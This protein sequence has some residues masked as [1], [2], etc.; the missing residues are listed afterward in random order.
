MTWFLDK[1][2][3]VIWGNGEELLKEETR[4]EDSVEASGQD[5]RG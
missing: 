3:L 4:E 1:A 5:C 2:A